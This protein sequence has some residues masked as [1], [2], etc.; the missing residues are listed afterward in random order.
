M[1]PKPKLGAWKECAVCGAEIPEDR[2]AVMPGA[3]TC[4]KCQE[5]R[6]LANGTDDVRDGTSG[7]PAS[8]EPGSVE[9]KGNL[10]ISGNW[11]GNL[12]DLIGRESEFR[13]LLASGDVKRVRSLM[14]ALPVQEQAALVAMSDAPEEML[15]MTGA[16]RSGVPGYSHRVV[17]LLPA[18]ILGNLVSVNPDEW[19]FNTELIRAMSP[20]VLRR[21]M[22]ETLDSVDNPALRARVSW[23]WLKA[24][25]TLKEFN[26]RAALLRAVDPSLLE[27]ALLDR[28]DDLNL[29]E[30]V[31]PP[32]FQVYRFRLFSAEGLG[33]TRP[34]AF[35]DDPETGIVLDALYE[36]APT[37][38][39]RVI[40]GAWER[41]EV[42]KDENV[43][44]AQQPEENQA[45]TGGADQ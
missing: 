36:A 19:K 39:S 8:A 43:T 40:R 5:E 42:E 38:L 33:G 37:L 15:S 24:L 3:S 23:E 4:V 12:M 10:V 1:D 2:R 26:R 9:V 32:G 44:P 27:D 22:A 28:M 14:Q 31:G 20:G 13:Q 25:A 17:E 11:S 45:D 41:S 29:N 18:E 21:T 6:E 30:I 16:D 35:I 7:T 34:S